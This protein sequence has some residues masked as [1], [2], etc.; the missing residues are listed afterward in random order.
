MTRYREYYKFIFF[1][2]INPKL[3]H[4]YFIIKNIYYYNINNVIDA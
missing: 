1:N 2:A 4:I 3:D